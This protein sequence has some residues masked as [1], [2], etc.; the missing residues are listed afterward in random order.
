MMWTVLVAAA[1]SAAGDFDLQTLGGE[2]AGGRLVELSATELVLETPSGRAKFAVDALA[3]LVRRDEG[4]EFKKPTMWIELSDGSGL[5][6][7]EYAVRGDTASVKLPS[8]RWLELST[9]AIRWVRFT[10]PG[11]R[12]FKVS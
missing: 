1:L 4:P 12:W 5:P 11:D 6:G 3:N 7:I 8:G 9:K 2:A 10:P